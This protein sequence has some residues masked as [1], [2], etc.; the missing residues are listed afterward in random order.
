MPG[1]E[2]TFS[3]QGAV[4]FVYVVLCLFVEMVGT[5]IY[6]NLVLMLNDVF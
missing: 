1:T 3:Q 5:I 6:T 4:S 2:A